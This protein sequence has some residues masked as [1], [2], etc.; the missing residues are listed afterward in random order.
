GLLGIAFARQAAE[1]FSR[2][3]DTADRYHISGIADLL[4]VPVLDRAIQGLGDLLPVTAEQIEGWLIG[5]GKTILTVLLSASGSFFAGAL[6]ALIGSALTL[7][8]L[9]FFLRDGEDWAWRA[10]RLIPLDA[11]RK[12]QLVEHLGAVARAVAFGALL[13]ALIQGALVGVA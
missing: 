9:F 3:Q 7:F 13:T 10:V 5:G 1:L 4:R 12:A 6:G 11:P 8:L 2:L